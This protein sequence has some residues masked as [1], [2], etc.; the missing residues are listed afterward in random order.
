MT[1]QEFKTRQAA[2]EFYFNVPEDTGGPPAASDD[3]KTDAGAPVATPKASTGTQKTTMSKTATQ[4]AADTII[5]KEATTKVK[6]SATWDSDLFHFCRRVQQDYNHEIQGMKNWLKNKSKK[7]GKSC[8]GNSMGCGDRSCQTSKDYIKANRK[9]LKGMNI[10]LTCDAELDFVQGLIPHHMDAIQMCKILAPDADKYLRSLCKNITKGSDEKISYMQKWLTDL[11]HEAVGKPCATTT[12]N[13]IGC[14]K[15]DCPFSKKYISVNNKMHK[16]MAVQLTCDNAYDFVMSM[17]PRRRGAVKMCDALIQAR[18]TTPK[19][20]QY[21]PGGWK[22]I[23]TFGDKVS[24]PVGCT[25]FGLS[26]AFC[27]FAF[28]GLIGFIVMFRG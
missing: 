16:D 19:D 24:L 2:G 1:R 7:L 13:D 20:D 4:P 21:E 5:I 23:V 27:A 25:I 8:G 11:E 28:G 12:G 18:Y 6:D 9:V 15:V 26:I 17:V 14:G 22:D 10:T 3:A